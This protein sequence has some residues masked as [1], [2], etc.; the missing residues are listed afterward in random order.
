MQL[1]D[2][3]YILKKNI[4]YFLITFLVTIIIYIIFYYT[5]PVSFTASCSVLSKQT[6]SD[7]TLQVVTGIPL[8]GES[9]T[10]PAQRVQKR[11]SD[12]FLTS[13][14]KFTHILLQE[15]ID[16]QK[17]S[18]QFPYIQQRANILTTYNQYTQQVR[19]N[20]SLTSSNEI[21]IR[22]ESQEKDLPVYV[23]AGFALAF[24]QDGY[25]DANSGFKQQLQ[26]YTNQQE[27]VE[28][29]LRTIQKNI[30]FNYQSRQEDLKQ[31]ENIRNSIQ[32]QIEGAKKIL[33][34]HLRTKATLYYL[35]KK[36]YPIDRYFET[37]ASAK[38]KEIYATL[39]ATKMELQSELVFKM[40]GHPLIKKL[41]TKIN[42]LQ[43]ALFKSYQADIV[44]NIKQIEENIERTEQ[45]IKDLSTKM[46]I[47]IDKIDKI[48]QSLSQVKEFIREEEQLNKQMEIIRGNIDKYRILLQLNKSFVEIY[49]TPKIVTANVF[50]FTKYFPIILLLGLVFGF[51]VA[52]LVEY[53]EADIVTEVD[54]KKYMGYDCIGM[55]PLDKSGIEEN[56]ILHKKEQF[57]L[58]LGD[59]YNSVASVLVKK[60]N[61]LNAKYVIISG[62]GR[63]EGKTTVSL[64][65]TYT[66]ANAGYKCA[67]ID[68]DLRTKD[69][70]S[71]LKR[72]FHLDL[73]E[74]HFV[75]NINY[76][77][78]PW[79]IEEVVRKIAQ[80]ELEKLF[81]KLK[82]EYDF[83]IVDGPPLMSVGETPFM[84]R[85]IENVLLVMASGE[86]SKAK[87]RWVKHL[88]STLGVNVL[89]VILNK[90]PLEIT[91]TY[92]YYYKYSYYRR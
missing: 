25:E 91:P 68:M 42:S 82:V 62:V 61:D 79:K 92:Y 23:C 37:F 84:I 70:T 2:Y 29:R 72:Y 90:A 40:E 67:L 75:E 18:E 9:S 64:N 31:L 12:T 11:Y 55:I 20:I 66:L 47:Y 33:D 52:Y 6:I 88:I 22:V 17:L 71:K 76:I 57:L 58:P 50:K 26:Y 65:L 32:E 16:M 85:S 1:S 24:L 38:T 7:I 44:N 60:M 63:Y 36:N 81:N 86:V 39:N 69:L 56:I 45:D 59:I 83:I 30:P 28:G 41:Y 74:S 53:L 54:V 19:Y 78:I 89:G 80:G 10:T 43:D 48:S 15:K 77:G 4:L 3:I 27:K 13:V 49:D 46:Q 35:V 87:S 14:N 34:N 73:K 8:I 51:F 5:R 21:V